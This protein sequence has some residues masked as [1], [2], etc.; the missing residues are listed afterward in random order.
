MM[1][2]TSKPECP[3]CLGTSVVRNG[4]VRGHQRY[5][6]G[7]CQK[8]FSQG[9]EHRWPND[10]KLINL[11]L[12]ASGESRDEVAKGCQATPE[13]VGR[14][15]LDAKEQRDWFIE[16]LAD[17][18]YYAVVDRSESLED[19]FEGAIKLYCMVTQDTTELGV[20]SIVQKLDNL[21]ELRGQSAKCDDS[22]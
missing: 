21:L 1:T 3:S 6:C 7:F 9:F 18:E 10:S 16:V 4:K 5:K 12:L 22:Q 19:A 8:N 13:T 20:S 11:L 2:D 17:A 14:W 15:L